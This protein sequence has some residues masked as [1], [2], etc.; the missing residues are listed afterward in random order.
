MLLQTLIGWFSYQAEHCSFKAMHWLGMY[1]STLVAHY[2]KSK[3]SHKLLDDQDLSGFHGIDRST[4][5]RQCAVYFI[6]FQALKSEAAT[7]TIVLHYNKTLYV[8]RCLHMSYPCELPAMHGMVWDL[9]APHTLSHCMDPTRSSSPGRSIR[10]NF[11]CSKTG[12]D[13]Y[14]E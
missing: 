11:S 7:F 12:K 2:S 8:R 4:I 13:S 9:H 14:Y 10:R 5:T 3:V 6:P 1:C